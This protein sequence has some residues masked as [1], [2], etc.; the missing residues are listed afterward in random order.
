MKNWKQIVIEGTYDTHSQIFKM[1]NYNFLFIDSNDS[2]LA[3]KYGIKGTLYVEATGNLVR[4]YGKG[5]FDEFLDR[6]SIEGEKIP[7]VGENKKWMMIDD[8]VR[9]IQ[10]AKNIAKK[11]IESRKD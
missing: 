4:D 8:M 6:K 11:F 7:G 1:N 10:D 5:M 2:E 3:Q 9:H